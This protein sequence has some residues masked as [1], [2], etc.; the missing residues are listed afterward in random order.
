M[1]GNFQINGHP[2]HWEGQH[3]IWKKYLYHQSSTI[4]ISFTARILIKWDSNINI[5]NLGDAYV[6]KQD[7]V[8]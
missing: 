5:N 8:A 2:S 1:K 3:F 6:H 7:Q 4:H